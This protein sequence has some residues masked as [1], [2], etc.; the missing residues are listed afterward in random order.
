ML[1]WP[2]LAEAI[3]YQER[4]VCETGGH[5]G[6]LDQA[7]L[8]AALARPL[9][10]VFEHETFPT[11]VLKVAA[12]IDSIITTHPFLDGN[13]RTAMR[14]GLA[15]MEFNCSALD[16]PT[17]QEIEDLAVGIATGDISIVQ[18]AQWPAHYYDCRKDNG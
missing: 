5:I 4:V 10:V 1:R 6:V 3:L 16:D 2:S 17:D 18:C 11:P 8:E 12:L 14:L 13:K 7:K 9:I 15:V